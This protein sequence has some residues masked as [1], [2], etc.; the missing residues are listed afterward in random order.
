M[1]MKKQL[2]LNEKT[3]QEFESMLWREERE[4][5]TIESYL[6]TLRQFARWVKTERVDKESAIAWKQFLSDKG[7][8]SVTINAK[9]AAVNKFFVCFGCGAFKVKYLRVQ[10]RVFRS[11]GRDLTRREYQNLVD[12]ARDNGNE[13][14]ALCME[15]ICATGIRVSE[16][17][18]ITVE[19]VRDGVVEVALKGKIRT[20]LIPGKLARKLLRYAKRGKIDRGEIFRSRAGKS[21]SRKFIWAEMK[22]C[23]ERA[24]VEKSKVFPHN[25]RHLFA[26]TFYQACRDMVKLADVLG[27]SSME[28]TRIYLMT[29]GKEYAR[30]LNKLGLVS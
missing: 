20:I 3:I 9:L 21:L 27:H 7:Y 12:C 4:G 28:T 11:A 23:C 17:R 10:R 16:L 5:S 19:A 2:V 1:G 25:L 24:G 22:R 18:Y 26:R 8:R 15:T 14:L 6:R 29:T 13:R 30:Q